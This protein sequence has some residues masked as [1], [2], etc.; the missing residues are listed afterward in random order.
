MSVTDLVENPVTVRAFPNPFNQLTNF[1]VIGVAD[2]YNFELI[3]I[4]GRVVSKLSSIATSHFQI[5]REGLLAGVYIYRI[6]TE[7]QPVAY[8]K[9]VIE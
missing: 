1:E 7:N 9:L 8:G 5:N 2:K 4:T 3:D 6:Y